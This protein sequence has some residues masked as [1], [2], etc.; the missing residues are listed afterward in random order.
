VVT[1]TSR[2]DA[3]VVTH[4]QS[5]AEPDDWIA[6]LSAS[7]PG[8]EEALRQ[9]HELLLRA[10]R[11]Q[12][13]RMRYRL[14]DLDSARV[15][16]LIHQSADEAMVSLLGKLSSFEG[17]S[18]FTTWAYKFAIVQAGVEV[19]RHIWRRRDIPLDGVAEPPT[20]EASPESIIEAA[21]LSAAVTAA[22]RD[23]LTA[24]QRRVVTALVIDEV[25]V[26]VLAE[27]LGTS[28]NSLYKT[29]HDARVRLRSELTIAGYSV[30]TQRGGGSQ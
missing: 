5:A 11:H 16:E 8:H 26:D 13:T 2:D 12:V 14:G 30:P 28:R 10:A 17:R 6:L 24:H 27:R 19:N 29:L 9:L 7:G 22:I 23:V 21:D 1:A 18:S 3:L 20:P 4:Q 15:E 25:P